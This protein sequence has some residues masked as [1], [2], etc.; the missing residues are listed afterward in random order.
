MR[1]RPPVDSWKLIDGSLSLGDT[2]LGSRILNVCSGILDQGC[3]ESE[4]KED[5]P[6]GVIVETSKT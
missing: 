2:T 5:Y 1:R 4:S 3:V 6:Q